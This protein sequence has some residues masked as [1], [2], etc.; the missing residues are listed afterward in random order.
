MLEESH[1]LKDLNPHENMGDLGS[2]DNIKTVKL[3]TQHI[4]I[5]K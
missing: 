2:R 5:S 3:S 1:T 4:A